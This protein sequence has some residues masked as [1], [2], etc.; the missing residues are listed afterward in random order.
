[1]FVR[2]PANGPPHDDDN[3]YSFAPNGRNLWIESV[4]ASKGSRRSRD[5]TRHFSA[6]ASGGTIPP[7]AQVHLIWVAPSEATFRLSFV[8]TETADISRSGVTPLDIQNALDA[9]FGAGKFEVFGFADGPWEVQIV[10][11][12]SVGETPV[13]D[14]TGIT[15]PSSAVV[16]LVPDWITL[17]VSDKYQGF[18]GPLSTPP[19]DCIPEM[20]GEALPHSLT[21][22]AASAV[23]NDP[24]TAST[25]HVIRALSEVECRGHLDSINAYDCAMISV[26]LFHWALASARKI[27]KKDGT[28]AYPCSPL[29]LPAILAL[30]FRRNQAA[31]AT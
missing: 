1:M 5:F 25:Y 6:P 7:S 10:A 27:K 16:R 12:P 14:I 3:V 18:T 13:I 21:G 23:R 26:G 4:P 9:K 15:N 30:N 2:T 20:G 28:A 31:D 29:E 22:M 8:G 11:N 24:N 17:G 19:F